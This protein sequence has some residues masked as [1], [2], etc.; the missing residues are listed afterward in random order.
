MMVYETR[1]FSVVGLPIDFGG[2]GWRVATR[3]AAPLDDVTYALLSAISARASN[4]PE[5][6]EAFAAAA[7]KRMSPES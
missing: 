7:L 6:A 1:G 4:S 2:L 5:V 3:E